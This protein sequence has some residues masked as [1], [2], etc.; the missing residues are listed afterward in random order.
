M[1]WPC[2]LTYLVSSL[3]NCLKRI[4]IIG[5][6]RGYVLLGRKITRARSGDAS[7]KTVPQRLQDLCMYQHTETVAAQTRSIHI[8]TRQ[9]LDTRTGGHKNPTPNQEIICNRC[10]LSQ[11]QH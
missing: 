11:G 4:W 6:V 7:M 9:N 2:R 10:L 1:I 3:W 8:Q 5:I